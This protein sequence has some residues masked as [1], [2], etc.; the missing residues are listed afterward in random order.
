MANRRGIGSY[1]P[2]APVSDPSGGEMQGR[3]NKGGTPG[4]N[5]RRKKSDPQPDPD[6][7]QKDLD[8]YREEM[9]VDAP[10]S[11]SPGGQPVGRLIGENDPA[12]A[13]NPCA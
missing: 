10:A 7:I 2:D 11:N 4:S 1:S 13:L 6:R 5:K 12:A 8:R 3:A 9:A